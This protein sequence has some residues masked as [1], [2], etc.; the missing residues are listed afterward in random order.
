MIT[1][2]GLLD[3]RADKKK[4]AGTNANLDGRAGKKK[5]SLNFYDCVCQGWAGIIC[6]TKT[7]EATSNAFQIT[8]FVKQ[9]AFP[10]CVGRTQSHN[11]LEI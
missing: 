6:E 3:G 9:F 4:S 10:R 1:T 11:N 2:M 5:E 8:E 7:A